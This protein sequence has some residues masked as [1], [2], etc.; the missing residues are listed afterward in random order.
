MFDRPFVAYTDHRPLVGLLKNDTPVGLCLCDRVVRWL[1]TIG[2][3]QMTLKYRPGSKNANA[4]MLNR[5]PLPA[6]G[7]TGEDCYL[8]IYNIDDVL[9][10]SKIMTARDK[11]WI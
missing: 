11:V 10:V 8:F 7:A 1:L 9:S 2:S 3:Y 4:D 6:G 5:L